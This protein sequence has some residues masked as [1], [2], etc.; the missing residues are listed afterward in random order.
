MFPF[1]K[2]LFFDETVF[3]R[4]ARMTIMIAG[5]MVQAGQIPGLPPWAGALLMG[6]AMF[7]GAGEKNRE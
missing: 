3:V 4:A 2:R 5:G 1:L 6:V 7:L